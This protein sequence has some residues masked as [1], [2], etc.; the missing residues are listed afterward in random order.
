MYITSNSFVDGVFFTSISLIFKKTQFCNTLLL[1]FVYNN[2][3]YHCT[4][5]MFEDEVEDDVAEVT[6][7]TPILGDMNEDEIEDDNPEVTPPTRIL[8]EFIPRKALKE[9]KQSSTTMANT[10]NKL[11][12]EVKKFSKSWNT[13]FDVLRPTTFIAQTTRSSRISNILNFCRFFLLDDYFKT[14]GKERYI[15]LRTFDVSQIR[16]TE[17]RQ[18]ILAHYG[19]NY[20]VDTIFYKYARTWNPPITEENISL[21]FLLKHP[22]ILA[23]L[24]HMVLKVCNIHRIKPS[25]MRL[26]ISTL[27]YSVLPIVQ[28]QLQPK[29]LLYLQFG[30]SNLLKQS[31]SYAQNDTNRF[32]GQQINFSWFD[33]QEIRV[34]C[35]SKVMHM[36]ADVT[37]SSLL[38]FHSMKITSKSP[39]KDKTLYIHTFET[40]VWMHR[41]LQMV[42]L[43]A[44]VVSRAEMLQYLQFDLS[45]SFDPRN[46]WWHIDTTSEYALSS[47]NKNRDGKKLRFPLTNLWAPKNAFPEYWLTLAIETRE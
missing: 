35:Q 5:D 32:L 34:L 24:Q 3:I 6:Q 9:L 17:L 45:L 2:S 21:M 18:C 46:L 14:K 27:L 38:K 8:G 19:D 47:S 22:Q 41:L 44:N 23:M 36:L 10:L 16:L 15:P 30:L 28:W 12:E 25:T 42:L 40:A 1:L 37:K 26:T 7:A 13:V 11:S 31:A 39:E 4:I 20:Y 43:T 33:M 29:Q